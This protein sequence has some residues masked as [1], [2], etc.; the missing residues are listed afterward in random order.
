MERRKMEGVRNETHKYVFVVTEG[1]TGKK[2]CVNV[3]SPVNLKNE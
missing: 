2:K 1:K 3:K